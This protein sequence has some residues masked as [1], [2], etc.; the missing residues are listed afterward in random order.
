M[1]YNSGQCLRVV[2]HETSG[3]HNRESGSDTKRRFSAT[4]VMVIKKLHIYFLVRVWKMSWTFPL[5]AVG[6]CRKQRSA[7]DTRWYAEDIGGKQ[8]SPPT[9]VTLLIFCSVSDTNRPY[10][11]WELNRYE[12]RHEW[13][14]KW[15]IT[16]F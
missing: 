12:I 7:R 6:F 15:Y 4:D 8:D 2:K 5:T 3:I 9:T 1:H 10:H 13:R 11:W 16:P 14:H